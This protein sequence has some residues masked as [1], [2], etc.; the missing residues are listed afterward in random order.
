VAEAVENCFRLHFVCPGSNG[1][2]NGTEDVNLLKVGDIVLQALQKKPVEATTIV[3][4]EAADDPSIAWLDLRG[5]VWGQVEDYGIS[6]LDVVGKLI[7]GNVAIEV[8]HDE[9]DLAP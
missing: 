7:K 3:R 5:C 6:Q 4:L 1:H 9:E 2:L 8:I